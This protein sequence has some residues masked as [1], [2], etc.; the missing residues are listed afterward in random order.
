MTTEHRFSEAFFHSFTKRTLSVAVPMALLAVGGG[1]FISKG[2]NDATSLIVLGILLAL[3][4]FFMARALQRNKRSFRNFCIQLE[5]DRLVRL[6]EGY[7]RFEISFAEITKITDWPGSGL[8]VQGASHHHS[9]FLP[10][11]LERFDELRA[12]LAEHHVIEMAAPTAWG[13]PKLI[14]IMLG[15]LIALIVALRANSPLVVWIAGCLAITS[16]IGCAVYLAR[17][18]HVDR[19]TKRGLWWLIPVFL[20]IALKMWFVLGRG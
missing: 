15:P 20:S 6:Q 3:M 12:R 11:S 5:D 4:A 19:R 13:L 18:P 9:I 10:T 14:G 8:H 2:G 1:W 16:L 7:P 17:N